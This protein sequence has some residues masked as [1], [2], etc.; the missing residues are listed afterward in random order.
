MNSD[1]NFANIKTNFCIIFEL[2]HFVEHRV[3]IAL[4][5]FV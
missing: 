4:Q 5:V 3:S 1:P 2:E